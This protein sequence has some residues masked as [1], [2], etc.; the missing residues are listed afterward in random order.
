[1]IYVDRFRCNGCG[2]CVGTC[3]VGAITMSGDR[4]FIDELLCEGCEACLSACPQDA[5]LS[6][7]MVE[8]IAREERAM[9]PVSAKFE[10]RPVQPQQ[11]SLSLRDQILP[12]IGSALAWT[13]KEIVPRLASQVL[14]WWDQRNQ[15]ADPV[16]PDPHR[17]AFRRTGGRGRRRQ[18]R[19]R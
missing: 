15:T 13:G 7:E 9:I 19:R 17:Q 1:V 10:V 3:L 8:S 11:S 2:E 18:R 6:V 16:S 14:V 4:V 12:A 5:I